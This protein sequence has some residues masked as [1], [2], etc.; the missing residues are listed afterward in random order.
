[1]APTLI[2]S[3]IKDLREWP[4]TGATLFVRS[5]FLLA[6]RSLFKVSEHE[7]LDPEDDIVRYILIECVGAHISDAEL[8]NLIFDHE[9]DGLDEQGIIQELFRSGI[10]DQTQ[11]VTVGR[12]GLRNY[13]FVEGGQ[14]V[15][16]FQVAG[17]YIQPTNHHKGIMS[18]TYL[19][20]LN[21]YEHLVCDDMQTIP[22][23]R[24]WA[25]P[26]VRA[27]EVRIY[28]EKGKLFEDVLGEKG[29]GRH[30]GFLPWN[31]GRLFDISSWEPNKLQAMVQKFIVLIISRGTCLRIG[32]I[33]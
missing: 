27:G 14:P 15:G 32:F 16:C 33:P 29:I 1:M 24:I 10:I 21:W 18:R 5:G 22:G 6:S 11:N 26:M 12:V 8:S 25:G 4:H 2:E 23:A 3:Y 9:D 20:L 17:A 7:I 28:N 30:T 13:S 19:F 31:K